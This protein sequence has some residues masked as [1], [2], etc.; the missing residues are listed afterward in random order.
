MG[1]AYVKLMRRGAMD[2]QIAGV[3][4]QI[5]LDEDLSLCKKV[6]IAM[7]GVGPVPIR[8]KKAETILQ[9]VRIVEE[10]IEEAALAAIQDAQPIT[11]V[12]AT[13]EYRRDMIGVLVKRAIKL[14]LQRTKKGEEGS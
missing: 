9:G 13:L 3:S 7:G 14:S 5:G 4:V 2:L 1:G 8:A 6:R 12:R 11:D 10:T